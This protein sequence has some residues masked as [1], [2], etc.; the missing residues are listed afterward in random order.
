MPDFRIILG[1]FVERNL[2]PSTDNE[3]VVLPGMPQQPF[4][5]LN[6]ADHTGMIAMQSQHHII[7]AGLDLFTFK[8]EY[9]V[10]RMERAVET[11]TWRTRTLRKR[12]EWTVAVQARL[13]VNL[14]ISTIV[15]KLHRSH[16][17]DQRDQHSLQV[18]ISFQTPYFTAASTEGNTSVSNCISFR[19]II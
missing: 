19:Y 5:V 18:F 1:A 9:G 14:Q 7:R 16:D 2:G 3:L 4:F 6:Q 10:L 13:A 8:A 11:Q 12:L 15:I 17:H